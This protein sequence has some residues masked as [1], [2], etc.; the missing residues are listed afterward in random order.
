MI[1]TKDTLRFHFSISAFLATFV[2]M[3]RLIINLRCILTVCLSVLPFRHVLCHNLNFLSPSDNLAP[4]AL[5][6]P[7]S[8]QVVICLRFTA[9]VDASSEP[10]ICRLKLS[11]TRDCSSKTS[12]R[13]AKRSRLKIKRKLLSSKHRRNSPCAKATMVS[14]AP[15]ISRIFIKDSLSI[16]VD[17]FSPPESAPP[18]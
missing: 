13:E 2:D 4:S 18:T 16:F 10:W 5:R 14:S 17:L 6:L 3:H 1:V 7:S 12:S 15:M 8:I 11:S 9:N